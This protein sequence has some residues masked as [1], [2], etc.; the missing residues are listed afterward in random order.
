MKTLMV[1][2]LLA[3]CLLGVMA[4]PVAA[5][6]IGPTC[7]NIVEFEET[8]RFFALP[9]GGGQLILTGHSLTFGDAYSGS[10]YVSGVQFVFTLASGL[11]PGLLEGTIDLSTNQGA[12]SVTFADTSEIVPLTYSIVA[13]PPTQ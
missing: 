7:L 9:T 6:V 13:C 8:A 10:G 11:L 4:A 2:G 1:V 12:G 5:Q 3:F